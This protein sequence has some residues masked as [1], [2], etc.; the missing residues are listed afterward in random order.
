MSKYEKFSVDDYVVFGDGFRSQ[1][2][3]DEIDPKQRVLLQIVRVRE[4]PNIYTA[5]IV[6][7]SLRDKPSRYGGLSGYKKSDGTFGVHAQFLEYAP[8]ELV[9]QL[10]PEPAV[11]FLDAASEMY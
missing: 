5:Q 1:Y 11:D 8:A 7:P 3:N 6:D 9:S 4:T 2:F 10:M